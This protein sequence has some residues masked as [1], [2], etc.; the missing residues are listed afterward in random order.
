MKRTLTAA[1]VLSAAFS[2]AAC[3]SSGNGGST[4]PASAAGT[5]ASAASPGGTSSS[6][7]LDAAKAYEKPFLSS[8][9]S[10]NV[11]TPL[12][13]KPPAGKTLIGLDGGIGSQKVQAQYWKQATEDLG[14]KYVDLI[15]GTTPASEQAAMQ[16]AIQQ[17]PSGIL[18]SG[19]S[20]ATIA[21]QLQQAKQKGIWVNSGDSTD[22]PTGAMFQTSIAGPDPERVFA[23][24]VAAYVVVQSGG[25]AVIQEFSLPVYPILEEFGTDFREAIK[26]W[27]PACTV[28]E[29]PQ[30]GTDIGTATPQAVVS[31]V[32]AN[33]K[34]NWLIFDVGDLATGVNAALSSAGLTGLHIGGLGP[35]TPNLQALK[36][37]T[38]DAWAGYPDPI[39]SYRQVDSFARKLL[40]QPSVE[41]PLPTQLITQDNVDKLVT[42]SA[43][44]YVGVT[45]YRQ[46]FDKLW[47][48]GG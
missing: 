4:A 39:V 12:K 3:S 36:Q 31:T 40:G 30:Q 19:I 45:D 14:W 17:N 24:M 10:V 13:S 11:S 38:Q 26:E 42:D 47:L 7:G 28:S 16:S 27:C 34:T 21:A 18:T 37:K 46:Q 15:A 8:P 20:N 23:K 44:N 43:G 25:K 33:P 29:H 2:I 48:V 35:D 6:V 1:A 9:T 22:K 32:Q 41:A 5:A